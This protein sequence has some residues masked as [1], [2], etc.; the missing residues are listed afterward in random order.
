MF[1]VTFR[2]LYFEDNYLMHVACYHENEDGTC[3]RDKTEVTLLGRA[4]TL[5]ETMQEKLNELMDSV[6]LVKDDLVL[7][8]EI[9]EYSCLLTSKY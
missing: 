7:T 1:S 3:P 9:G 2:I 4:R 5:T 6:C 8:K